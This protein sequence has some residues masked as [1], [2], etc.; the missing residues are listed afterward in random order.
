MDFDYTV[1]SELNIIRDSIREFV[2]KECP[3]DKARELD[4]GA[5]FPAELLDKIAELGFYGLTVPEEYG[6]EGIS[7]PG[8]MIAVEELAVI[9]PV[10]AL[11]YSYHAFC[12]GAVL[13]RWGSKDQKERYL[14][15]LA[16]GSMLFT[17][18]LA[19]TPVGYRGFP[20]FEATAV[21]DGDGF[22][23]NGTRHL[24]NFAARADYC[25][26]PAQTK[27]AEGGGGSGDGR[28]EGLTIFIV[29]MENEGITID[30]TAKVGMKGAAVDTVT[31]DRLRIPAENILGGETQL[32]RGAEL[33][34][35]MIDM[36]NLG[37]AAL[38]L[39][40]ARGAYEYARQHARERVQFG[41]PIAKF[42]AVQYMLVE[43][44]AQIDALRL[45]AY[46]AGAAADRNEPFSE[47]VNKAMLQGL[48]VVQ[49]AAMYVMQIC[50][51]YGYAMEY[52]AQRYLRDCIA[53]PLNG[54]HPLYFK[55]AV[56]AMTTMA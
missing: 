5:I 23:L 43:L 55:A 44:S 3:R 31:F 45:L 47:E 13:A 30:N 1:N 17:C 46:R 49:K 26:V 7:L 35:N 34:H 18:A 36:I 21:A 56:G 10:S 8:A 9:H 54:V 19:E 50:G 33:L 38:C 6:G 24:V 28:K 37:S 48:E 32:H 12:G 27:A 20:S 22:M 42:E 15:D 11:A 2:S 39:G 53:L 25:L 14:D 4:E 16:Q 40:L 51:G 41:L 29:D 52:D